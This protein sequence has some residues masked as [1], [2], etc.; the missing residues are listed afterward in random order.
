[1]EIKS[2]NILKYGPLESINLTFQNG[3]NVIYGPNGSGKTLILEALQKFFMGRKKAKK[4]SQEIIE[5]YPI[6]EL[7]IYDDENR[8]SFDGKQT[9]ESCSEILCDDLDNIFIIKDGMCEITDE[10][11]FYHDIIPRLIGLDLDEI[12]IIKE[13]LLLQGRMTSP[14]KLSDRKKLNKPKTQLTKAKTLISEIEDFLKND[15]IQSGIGFLVEISQL[16]QQKDEITHQIEILEEVKK[17]GEIKK[18]EN[19]LEIVINN[20]EKVKELEK[21]EFSEL[22]G[23]CNNFLLEMKTIQDYQSELKT[24]RNYSFIY[25]ILS[26]I[27]VLTA[28]LNPDLLLLGLISIFGLLGIVWCVIGVIN[29]KNKITVRKN[30]KRDIFYSA[31]NLTIPHDNIDSITEYLTNNR[32]KIDSLSTELLLSKGVLKDSE[33]FKGIQ[34]EEIN[35]LNLQQILNQEKN[36]VDMT[37]SLDFNEDEFIALKETLKTTEENIEKLRV[38]KETFDKNL[39]TIVTNCSKI[40]FD[41]EDILGKVFEWEIANI[42]SLELY[43]EWLKEL[44]AVMEK[45]MEI[46]TE[47]YHIFDK[48]YEKETQKIAEFFNND[49]KISEFTNR[50]TNGL[51]KE[52]NYDPDEGSFILLRESDIKQNLDQISHGELSQLYFAVRLALGKKCIDKG[53]LLMENPFLASDEERFEEQVNLV[54][55]FVETGWQ[56]IILITKKHTEEKLIESGGIS[57]HQLERIS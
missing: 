30:L 55:N 20:S 7:V 54:K 9:I 13:N 5:D 26:L 52:V 17:I 32:G 2:L 33:L 35:Y 40:P 10:Q 24:W 46:N 43:L 6:G 56:I 45:D 49:T 44:V 31:K 57:V 18:L 48:I 50:I 36:K 21:P 53:F 47:A 27:P 11:E 1:M 42:E 39:H 28:F 25:F 34:V 19:H 8:I 51:F 16:K 29:T 41:F 23:K 37:I 15:L 38:E 22:E 12:E 4:V 14:S 3:L